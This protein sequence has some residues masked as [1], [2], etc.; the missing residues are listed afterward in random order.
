MTA[1]GNERRQMLLDEAMRNPN[2]SLAQIAE[3]CGIRKQSLLRYFP[4]RQ[5]LMDA[6]E[7]EGVTT[8]G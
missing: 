5:H 2:A 6:I 4:T 7:A 8:S 1:A 3:A